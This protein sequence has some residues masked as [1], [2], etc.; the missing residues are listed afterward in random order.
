MSVNLV[1]FFV[2]VVAVTVAAAQVCIFLA[3]LC[4]K[5]I[6]PACTWLLISVVPDQSQKHWLKQ[7][8]ACRP[9]AL[10]PEQHCALLF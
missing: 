7:L 8:S 5:R 9:V 4:F 3:H 1:A 6:A 10:R 2:A